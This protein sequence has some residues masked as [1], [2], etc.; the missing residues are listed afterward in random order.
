LRKRSAFIVEHVT[1][2][3]RR[4][5]VRLKVLDIGC[6]LGE[7]ALSVG[8]KGHEVTAVDIDPKSISFCNRRNQLANVV[9]RVGNGENLDLEETFDVVIVSEVLEHTPHPELLIRTIDN[10]LKKEGIA[11]LSVPNG[12]CP[13][14]IVV[15]RLIQKNR[16]TSML[17]KSRGTYKMLSGASTPFYSMNI[18]CLHIWFFSFKKLEGLLSKNGF[19]I[20]VVRHSDLG[21]LPE[22]SWL[23]AAKRVECKL[24]DI[25]PRPVA[26]GW[27]LVIRRKR[28]TETSPGR[29]Q[30]TRD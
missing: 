1:N 20:V 16:L 6:G 4:L 23:Q 7:V 17:Y 5:G 18:D 9:F 25:V 13:W 15:S 12:Y 2:H 27:L 29:L 19:D 26:G 3:A 14:E 30:E 10:C 22:W 11:I 28:C 24:A 8:A 21:I